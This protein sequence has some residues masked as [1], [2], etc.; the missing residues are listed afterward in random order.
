M[1]Q[2]IVIKAAFDKGREEGEAVKLRTNDCTI[3]RTN[4]SEGPFKGKKEVVFAKDL[5]KGHLIP[6]AGTYF[7]HDEMKQ[8]S[9]TAAR[10]CQVI[11]KY[12]EKKFVVVPDEAC[13][14]RFIEDPIGPDRSRT[15]RS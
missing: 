13:H 2:R 5:P 3:V 8:K 11:F 10:K 15:R 14:F 7:T 6:F 1:H 9:V 4:K 12:F